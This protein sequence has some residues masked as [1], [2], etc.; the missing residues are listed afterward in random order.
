MLWKLSKIIMANFPS[1]HAAKKLSLS[2]FKVKYLEAS[3][4]VAIQDGEIHKNLWVLS[5][6]TALATPGS[7]G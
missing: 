2:S 3:N 5:Q 7:C 1:L 4:T 6:E